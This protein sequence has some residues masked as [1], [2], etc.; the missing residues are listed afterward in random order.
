ML[1][2][3]YIIP[4]RKDYLLKFN[5][6]AVSTF[7]NTESLAMRIIIQKADKV[8]LILTSQVPCSA[9]TKD[10]LCKVDGT[11]S[12]NELMRAYA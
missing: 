3:V 1:N 4:I 2:Q 12:N 7:G 9:H 10:D 11:L 5:S 6:I 8:R